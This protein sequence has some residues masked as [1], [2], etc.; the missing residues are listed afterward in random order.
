MNKFKIAGGQAAQAIMTDYFP[1]LIDIKTAP[2]AANADNGS[3][4]MP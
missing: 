1:V 2:S 3:Y 4:R